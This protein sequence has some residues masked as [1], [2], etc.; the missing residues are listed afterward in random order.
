VTPDGSERAR[1]SGATP[2]PSAAPAPG[3]RLV[4]VGRVGRAHGLDGSF[5]VTRPDERLLDGVRELH[6]GGRVLRIERRAGTPARPILRF[7]G[8]ASREDVEAMRGAPLQVPETALPALD[9]DEYWAHELEGC[10]VAD[11]DRVVGT[12]RRL[13]PLPSCEALEVARAEGGGDLI[14]PLVR[15]CVRRVDVAARRIDVDLAFLG[16]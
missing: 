9:E 10:T 8:H 7:E 6:V 13:M 2:D 15:D 11:G 12:V 5:H 4:E 1:T 3:P 14:V 16:E